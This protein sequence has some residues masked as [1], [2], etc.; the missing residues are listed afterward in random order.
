MAEIPFVIK[1]VGDH[2]YIIGKLN[3]RQQFDVLR[4]L[5]GASWFFEQAT[6]DDA[7]TGARWIAAILTGSMATLPQADSDFIL[8]STLACVRRRGGQN[9]AGTPIQV[10]G[11]M[12]FEDITLDEM[13]ELS[14]LVL[15]ESLGPFF[16]KRREALRAASQETQGQETEMVQP[17]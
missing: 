9:G 6:S 3:A 14:D 17:E 8:D 13:L 12:M 2:E 16:A 7:S 15:Q 5:G 11:R 1:T 4:R 10:N